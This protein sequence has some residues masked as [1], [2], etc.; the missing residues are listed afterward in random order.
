MTENLEEFFPDTFFLFVLPTGKTISY[1]LFKLS[2]ES[3]ERIS[4]LTGT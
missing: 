3:Q 4:K 2:P 1:R